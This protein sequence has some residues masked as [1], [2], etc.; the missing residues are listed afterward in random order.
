MTIIISMKVMVHP[1]LGNLADETEEMDE[2]ETD[3]EES[4]MAS[5]PY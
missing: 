3:E 2:I 5:S 1:N 4:I